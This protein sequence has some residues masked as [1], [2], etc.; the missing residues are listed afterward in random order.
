[1]IE[2]SPDLKGMHSLISSWNLKA[3]LESD[4]FNFQQTNYLLS[5]KKTKVKYYL[6]TYITQE[7]IQATHL[8][9]FFSPMLT[10]SSFCFQDNFGVHKLKEDLWS[11]SGRRL[12]YPLP[13]LT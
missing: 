10:S 8:F 7:K 5:E 1:M 12:V 13:Q 4:C 6:L 3:P 9:L 2:I 11:G